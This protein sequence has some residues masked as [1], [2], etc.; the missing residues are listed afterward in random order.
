MA[1]RIFGATVVGSVIEFAK[2]NENAEPADRPQRPVALSGSN[3]KTDKDGSIDVALL[4]PTF[5]VNDAAV[6][7]AEG[8]ILYTPPAIKIDAPRAG[9]D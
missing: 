6:E 8:E 4:S 9:G 1:E 3:V 2:K 7:V 5:D